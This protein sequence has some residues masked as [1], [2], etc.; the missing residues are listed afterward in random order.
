[1]LRS[2]QWRLILIYSLIIVLAMVS[3]SIYLLQ[4]LEDYYLSKA[5]VALLT[6]GN[7]IYESLQREF[8]KEQ[9]PIALAE[10]LISDLRRRD[11]EATVLLIDNQG[12]VVAASFN[13]A[14]DKYRG[15]NVIS[16]NTVVEALG[17]KEAASG[18]RREE[19]GR[20]YYT[21]AIPISGSIKKGTSIEAV[22]LI[23]I[24]EPLDDT[25]EIL[26]EVMMR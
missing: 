18:V 16:Y 1:M 22:A 25:Y 14:A 19:S 15:A 23:F 13:V 17:N 21:V 10:S 6:S 3:V 2:I 24:Q 5:N 9:V 7:L 12:Y 11:E 20:R 26:R 8:K 4:R